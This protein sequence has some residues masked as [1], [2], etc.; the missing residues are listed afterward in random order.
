MRKAYLGKLK[1]IVVKVGTSVITTKD[2]RINKKRLESLSGEI[3]HLKGKGVEVLVVSSGAIGLGMALLN[4]KK[5][6]TVLAEQQACA[7]IGQNHLMNLY[8]D[9]LMTNGFLA[10]QVLL[11]QE[12]LIDRRRYLNAKNTLLTLLRKGAVPIINE[13]DTVSTDEIKFGDNDRLSALVTNLIH[14]DLLL[15][16][17]DVDGL[18]AFEKEKPGAL[19]K[20]VT[21]VDE[22]IKKLAWTSIRESTVGGMSSKLQAA[23][24]VSY[25]GI[26]CVIA[27]GLKEGVIQDV[28]EAKDIGTFFYPQKQKLLAKKCWLAFARPSR[29]Q[30]V[31][32]D[33][34]KEALLARGK[35]LLSSGIIEV[36]GNFKIHDLVSVLSREGKEFARGL[37]NYSCTEL[38]KIRGLKTN[39]LQAALGYQR[40]DEAIHR[41]NL[42]IL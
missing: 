4:L 25:A 1:R 9:F 29:G 11:T 30:I 6:P 31:V 37:V 35:S 7:A 14:A 3:A 16:L 17:S 40:E 23:Q 10:A 28:V 36:R 24:M 15:I 19:V 33:G 20:E 42:V 41:D 21:Q 5:R 8:D 34:A 18:Y 22:G 39:K 38:D 13:N 32:D 26:A 27:N 2:E 12:D